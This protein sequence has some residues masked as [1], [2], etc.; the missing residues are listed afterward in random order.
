[1]GYG[2]WSNSTYNAYQK[3]YA[4]KS[5]DQLFTANHHR[6]IDPALDPFRL[7]KRESRDS[8]DHPN[9]LAIGLF[10]DVTGSMGMVPEDLVRNQ[11]GALMDTMIKAGV[12]DPQ[13]MFSAIGDQ[14]SDR[15]PLQVGQF[16]SSTELINEA[17]KKLF[18]EGG[19]GGS[20][21]ESYQLAWHVA[22]NHTSIDCFEKRGKK[23]FLFTVGD[24]RSHHIA[25]GELLSRLYGYERT[26][27]NR[28]AAELLAK[29]QEQY[30]VFH[31]H[32]NSTGYRNNKNV[33]GYWKELLGKRFIPLDD[34]TKLGELI[35]NIVAVVSQAESTDTLT[36][37]K[38]SWPYGEDEATIL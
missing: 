34:H 22:A 33:F 10:L 26:P 29:A 7:G 37:G 4:G 2:K 32:I 36:A 11:L 6:R 12:D 1:M 27:A 25:E 16:E 9:S 15:A 23:G 13:I 19:G 21:E 14:Y 35:A 38:K 20:G 3:R 30:H 18:L 28:S 5:R 17:L 31:I 24:E 8:D